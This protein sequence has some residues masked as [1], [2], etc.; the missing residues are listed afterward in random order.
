MNPVEVHPE[1]VRS[2]PSEQSVAVQVVAYHNAPVELRRTAAAIAA[3]IRL[4]RREHDLSAV[5]L[6]LGDCSPEPLLDDAGFEGLRAVVGESLD[7]V[8]YHFFGANLGSAG[9]SN[10]LAALGSEDCIWVVNPDAYP[11]PRCAT[12]LL[13]ALAPADVG[14]AEARQIPIGH[15]KAYDPD[16]GETSWVTGACVMI[17]RAAFER[18]GGFDDQYF[19]LYCDDV[20]LSWRLRLAGFRIVHIPSA[21]VFHD[22]RPHADGGVRW[23]PHEARSSILGRLWLYRRYGRPDLEFALAESLGNSDDLEHRAIASEYRARVDQGDAPVEI[24]DAA[25]VAEFRNGHFGPQR[26]TYLS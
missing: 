16:S 8:S 25:E 7:E 6:R 22:K 15:P 26:F 23:S 2:L 9:G 4:A 20:D 11:S 5:S 18:V 3:S 10:A 1:L 21:A 17:A 14:A 13:G 24:P 12:E 19:P